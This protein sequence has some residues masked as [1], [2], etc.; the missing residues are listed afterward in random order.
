MT[1]IPSNAVFETGSGFSIGNVIERSFGIFGRNFIPFLILSAI[2]ASP[3]LLIDWN[4][5]QFSL[6]KPG[7]PA[8]LLGA[9]KG[10]LKTVLISGLLGL[11]VATV[12]RA[13]LIAAVFQSMRGQPINILDSIR[14]GL[15]RVLPIIGLLILMGLGIGAGMIFLIVPGIILYMMWYVALPACVVERL[16]PAASLSRSAGLT[17]GS[18]WKIFGLV[19]LI[20]I[21]GSIISMTAHAVFLLAHSQ[22]VFTVG[23]YVLQT[24]IFAIQSIIAL[25]LYHDLRVSKEGIDTDRIASVFD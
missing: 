7:D 11:L 8:V 17:K 5:A 2:C 22:V 9:A 25:V 13:A 4:Q 21:V 14:H 12:G 6:A 3:Y 10:L 20:W 1:D 16:G 19:I 15:A 24:L 18:R 23:E